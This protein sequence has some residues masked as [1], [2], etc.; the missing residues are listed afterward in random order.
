[1]SLRF[2]TE[3]LEVDLKQ[4]ILVDSVSRNLEVSDSI[5]YWKSS[6]YLLNLMKGYALKRAIS[7]K[8]ERLSQELLDLLGKGGT[9]SRGGISLSIIGDLSLPTRGCALCSK[10]QWKRDSGNCF[11]FHHRSHTGS[12]EEFTRT[13]PVRRGWKSL[14]GVG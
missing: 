8:T 14:V 3:F 9:K 4:A 6:P 11:G 1:M 5:G 13:A 7:A 10:I 2:K 12:R